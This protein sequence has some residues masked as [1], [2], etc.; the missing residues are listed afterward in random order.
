MSDA[1]ILDVLFVDDN[2]ATLCYSH[3]GT[4]LRAAVTTE[5]VVR[6][7]SVL[8]TTLASW[9]VVDARLAH[10]SGITCERCA[11]TSSTGS[12]S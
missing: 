1:T 9:V 8:R 3:G 7:N 5:P 6:V 2:G 10:L 4:E 11:I 12:R